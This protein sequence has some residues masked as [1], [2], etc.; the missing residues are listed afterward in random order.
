MTKNEIKDWMELHVGD[1][2]D[3]DIDYDDGNEY[4]TI[5][6]SIDD[7]LFAVYKCNGSISEKYLMGKGYVYG[8]YELVEVEKHTE[9][10]EVV[11]YHQKKEG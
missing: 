4:E 9:M 5:V 2:V 6:Y 10:V 1:K 7:R 8:E 11:T 3:H